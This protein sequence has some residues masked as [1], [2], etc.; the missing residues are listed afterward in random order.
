MNINAKLVL[1]FFSVERA[2]F[3]IDARLPARLQEGLQSNDGNGK[4]HLQAQANRG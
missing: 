1:G 2:I 3:S 4:V